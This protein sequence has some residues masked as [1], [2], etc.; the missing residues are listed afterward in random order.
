MSAT[1]VQPVPSLKVTISTVPNETAVVL[2]EQIHTQRSADT[3]VAFALGHALFQQGEFLRAVDVFG[4]ILAT[5]PAHRRAAFG[6]ARCLQEQGE[7][8]AA[9]AARTKFDCTAPVIRMVSTP[10]AFASPR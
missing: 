4:E 2:L 10:S 9:A 6:L 7:N 1:E 5:Q 3:D 8:T